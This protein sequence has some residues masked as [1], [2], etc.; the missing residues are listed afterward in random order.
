M[1][2]KI[3]AIHDEKAGCY[4]PPFVLH[5]IG[6]ATRAFSDACNDLNHQF[7]QHP[8]DYTLF[9]IGDYDDEHAHLT[10]D[11]SSWVLLARGHELVSQHKTNNP[12]L[13]FPEEGRAGTPSETKEQSNG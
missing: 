4:L 3:F 11:T 8:A 6:M 13:P 1:I 12:T 7:G 10:Q 9:Q 5:A 2:H